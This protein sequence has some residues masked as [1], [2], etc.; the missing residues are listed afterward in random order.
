MVSKIG[1]FY[2][3]EYSLKRRG[4]HREEVVSRGKKGGRQSQKLEGLH[5][6]V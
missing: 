4:L 1:V 6:G 3:R 5:G 2:G